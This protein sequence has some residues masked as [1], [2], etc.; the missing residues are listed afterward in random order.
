M[1]LAIVAVT[2]VLLASSNAMP[3][4]YADQEISQSTSNFSSNS[5]IISIPNDKIQSV[6]TYLRS[7]GLKIETVY[8]PS[9]NTTSIEAIQD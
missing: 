1:R 3:L 7:Q 8:S 5:T 4:G 2:A 9:L 6:L